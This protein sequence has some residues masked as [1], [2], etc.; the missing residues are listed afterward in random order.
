MT[1][2]IKLITRRIIMQ[3]EFYPKIFKYL[4]IPPSCFDKS[5]KERGDTYEIKNKL[6]VK[7]LLKQKQ[8]RR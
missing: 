4:L 7:L 3:K 1:Y 6:Y 5:K 8:E 2:C